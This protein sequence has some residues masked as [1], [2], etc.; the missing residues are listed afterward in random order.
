MKFLIPSLVV[1]S[2]GGLTGVGYGLKTFVFAEQQSTNSGV[3][4]NFPKTVEG[5]GFVQKYMLLNLEGQGSKSCYKQVQKSSDDA[6][7]EEKIDCQDDFWK[8]SDSE[9]NQTGIWIITKKDKVDL[10]LQNWD[11]KGVDSSDNTEKDSWTVKSYSAEKLKQFTYK[12]QKTS[13]SEKV[14]IKCLKQEEAQDVGKAEVSGQL[15]SPSH[16]PAS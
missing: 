10:V 11:L 1:G 6:A 3:V 12:C 5:E 7:A 4:N 16:V 14:K 9:N 13:E 2:L 15:E 8:L